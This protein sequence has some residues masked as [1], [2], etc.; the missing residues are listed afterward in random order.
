MKQI[1]L[2]YRSFPS[3]QQIELPYS[4]SIV[5]RRLLLAYMQN[6][7]LP[8]LPE[9]EEAYSLCNEDILVVWRAVH[10]LRQRP[11][12]ET[13]QIDCG[14]SATAMRFLMIVAIYE[15]CATFLIGSPQLMKR[16]EQDDCSFFALMGA[17]CQLHDCGVAITPYLPAKRVHL[18]TQWKSSQYCSAIL[19]CNRAL[20]HE[21]SFE[22]SDQ[23]PSYSYLRLTQELLAEEQSSTLERDWSAAT[24]W[25]QLTMSH[26]EALDIEFPGLQTNSLQPDAL[27]QRDAL[28][29][30]ISSEQIGDALQAIGSTGEERIGEAHI[31]IEQ[32]LDSFLPLAL[33]YIRNRKPFRIIGTS[34]LR[35]KESNRI[36]SFLEAMEWYNVGG[37]SITDNEI[38]WDGTWGDLPEMVMI[39]PH[40]DHR[41]A[42]AFA[43]FAV[44]LPR[45][46]TVLLDPDCI[47][48]SYPRFLDQLL[49]N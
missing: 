13:I 2:T 35:Y 19:I 43:V 3:R 26:P 15:R 1:A 40:G 25:Y 12:G 21:V 46:T 45:I 47:A 44:T 17:E 10:Q 8:P 29:M 38:S 41:V 27:I 6:K 49:G 34:N 18:T 28:Q 32:H 42:M 24:F 48:K 9:E 37:F 4:K 33:T 20:D 7:P 31:H 30:G 36:A 14:S 16:I 23:S 5:A 22:F 39:N 11:E